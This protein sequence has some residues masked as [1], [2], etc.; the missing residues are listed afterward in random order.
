MLPSSVVCANVPAAMLLSVVLIPWREG[1]AVASRRD[2]PTC[3]KERQTER[4]S[5]RAAFRIDEGATFLMTFRSLIH[6]EAGIAR[7]P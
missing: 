4:E 6:Q 1:E 5:E 3:P 2:G 7:D